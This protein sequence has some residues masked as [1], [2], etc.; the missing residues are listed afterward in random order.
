MKPKVEGMFS[1]D[2]KKYPPKAKASGQ[3]TD[4]E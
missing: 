1:G 3:P 4:I 2:E